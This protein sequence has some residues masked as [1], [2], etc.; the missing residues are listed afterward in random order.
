MTPIKRMKAEIQIIG[1][2]P[3]VLLPENVLAYVFKQAGKDKGPIPIKG[4]INGRLYTQTLVKFGGFWRLYV[5]TT[6][7]PHSPRRIGE[8]IDIT[9]TFDPVERTITPHPKLTKALAEN[10]AAKAVFDSLRPSLQHEIVRYIA[11]LKSENSVDHNILRAI[12]FLLGKGRFVGRDK[13]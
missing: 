9:V 1:I 3:Y 7:L 11:R 8:V 10:D 13:T 12:D 5:N 2:N 6:M 4:T